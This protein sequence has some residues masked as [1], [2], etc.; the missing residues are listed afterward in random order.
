MALELNTNSLGKKTENESLDLL[1]GSMDCAIVKAGETVND[2]REIISI[3][4][5]EDAVLSSLV[6]PTKEGAD[7]EVLTG[8]TEGLKNFDGVT[9]KSGMVITPG[10]YNLGRYYS[11]IGVTSGSV[12]IYYNYKKSYQ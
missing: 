1:T 8:V 10:N 9:L 5:N 3:V 11:E 6:A 2:G 4:V 7:E 12:M